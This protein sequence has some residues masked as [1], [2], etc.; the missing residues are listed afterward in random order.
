MR[1]QGVLGPRQ[2]RFSRADITCQGLGQAWGSN[3]IP[4]QTGGRESLNAAPGA[5]AR[6]T[7]SDVCRD[8]VTP[9]RCVTDAEL[10][11]VNVFAVYDLRRVTK[12]RYRG[13][14]RT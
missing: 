12:R 14:V 2:N 10:L 8:V 11:V 7:G 9:D 13:N 3:R 6:A 5:W 1:L 4:R